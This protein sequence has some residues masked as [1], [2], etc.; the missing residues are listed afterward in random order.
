MAGDA[1]DSDGTLRKGTGE[2]RTEGGME[3][4]N[5]VW[6]WQRRSGEPVSSRLA[7]EKPTG[8]DG[9]LGGLLIFQRI[10]GS[11]V[12]KIVKNN[13]RISRV[14]RPTPSGRPWGK[15]P[16]QK[17]SCKVRLTTCFWPI[18][19]QADRGERKEPRRF[20]V[21]QAARFRRFV[22]RRRAPHSCFEKIVFLRR[23]HDN[24]RFFPPEIAFLLFDQSKS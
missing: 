11:Q 1:L 18:G 9:F 14:L 13:D 7:P 23:R 6:K 12:G 5:I 16:A 21:V 4:S 10:P 8:V 22:S 20:P 2:S 15:E 19:R 17:M 3:G 24:L